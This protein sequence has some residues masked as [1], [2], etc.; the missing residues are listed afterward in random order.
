MEDGMGKIKTVTIRE[1]GGTVVTADFSAIYCPWC[2][3]TVEWGL[4]IEPKQFMCTSCGRRGTEDEFKEAV[5]AKE[6]PEPEGFGLTTK[7]VP[8][9][10]V[11]EDGSA[12]ILGDPDE[13]PE[14][15]H[16]FG[17]RLRKPEEDL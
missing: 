2:D 3:G 14:S 6:S 16:P 12:E 1:K 7:L 13:Y 8:P 15:G 17:R 5:I 9:T 11:H 10:L 4:F